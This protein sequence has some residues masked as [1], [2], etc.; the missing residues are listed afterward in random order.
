MRT[1]PLSHS[2]KVE[3]LKERHERMEKLKEQPGPKFRQYMKSRRATH[4][5]TKRK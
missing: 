5:A 2:M 4:D 3:H 1:M